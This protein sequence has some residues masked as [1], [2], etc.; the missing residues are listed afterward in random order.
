MKELIKILYITIYFIYLFTL[1]DHIT[2]FITLLLREATPK[3][4]GH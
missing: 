1:Q 2:V 3:K 4:A